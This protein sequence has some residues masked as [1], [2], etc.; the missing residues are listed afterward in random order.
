MAADIVDPPC[1]CAAQ[2][3]FQPFYVEIARRRE[4]VLVP[5]E[6]VHHVVQDLVLELRGLQLVGIVP[7]QVNR[8]R[9]SECLEQRRTPPAQLDIGQF[10]YD[11]R[12]SGTPAFWAL[13][14]IALRC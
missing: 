11:L 7:E 5:V 2:H 1:H 3:V 4:S 12:R 13:S 9:R 10:I 14:R 8:L 6:L